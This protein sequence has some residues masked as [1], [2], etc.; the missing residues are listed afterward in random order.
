M[1]RPGRNYVP[2]AN[3]IGIIFQILDDYLNLQSSTYATNKG[4]C[5]DLSE[6]KFSFPVVHA[7]RADAS[8]RQ[9]LNILRAKPTDVDTKA[10]AVKYMDEVTHSFAYTRKVLARL[11]VDARGEVE[12]L[13]GNRAV[14]AILDKLEAGWKGDAQGKVASPVLE[15]RGYNLPPASPSMGL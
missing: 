13:G 1:R 4:Y 6:G 10:Y 3:L 15:R 8:N 5:E 12:K 14:A 2:L 7:I 9:L 11:M